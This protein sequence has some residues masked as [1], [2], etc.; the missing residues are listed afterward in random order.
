LTDADLEGMQIA[1]EDRAILLRGVKGIDVNGTLEPA[2]SSSIDLDPDEIVNSLTNSASSANL[3]PTIISNSGSTTVLGGQEM[4]ENL[5]SKMD[6]MLAR[7]ITN[8]VVSS[9]SN[10]NSAQTIPL[11]LDAPTEINELKNRVRLLEQ[12]VVIQS[13]MITSLHNKMERTQS[14]K[15]SSPAG[16]QS[17]SA[18]QSANNSRSSS[19][20]P[21]RPTTT[22]TAN[23]TSSNTTSATTAATTAPTQAQPP[24]GSFRDNSGWTTAR[25]RDQPPSA[26]GASALL[27]ASD[28]KPRG[29][30]TA[31]SGDEWTS[32][33]G[34]LEKD[35]DQIRQGGGNAPNK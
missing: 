6:V 26:L 18:A 30:H 4:Y 35:F 5:K 33:I 2:R 13:Q 20:Q 27:K 17:A 16:G 1:V 32:L 25:P 22:T 8:A 23:V 7:L 3:G 9:N 10:N 15:T 31:K 24:T 11:Q 29:Q 21:E 34:Q 28:E 14:K 19:P 12:I